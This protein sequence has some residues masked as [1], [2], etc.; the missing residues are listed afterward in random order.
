MIDLN[1]WSKQIGPFWSKWLKS[2]KYINGLHFCLQNKN[3]AC[4]YE[5]DHIQSL[6]EQKNLESYSWGSKWF[7]AW[8]LEP[9]QLTFLFLLLSVR[10]V[11]YAIVKADS[12]KKIEPRESKFENTM[13]PRLPEHLWD[14]HQVAA[15]AGWLC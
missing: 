4:N 15:L 3:H 8:S 7:S 12:K 14:R 5:N 1:S 6:K 11:T 2:S 10:V 13:K 9:T